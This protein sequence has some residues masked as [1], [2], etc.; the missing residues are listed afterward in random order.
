MD[1]S[2]S[3]WENVDLSFRETQTQCFEEEG[4]KFSFFGRFC[5]PIIFLLSAVSN[6]FSVME[7]L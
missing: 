3:V 7:L 2:R 4:E 1:G 6:I 5:R